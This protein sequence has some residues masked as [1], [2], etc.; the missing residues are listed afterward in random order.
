MKESS[1][2][3]NFVF[4]IVEQDEFR[5][6]SMTLKLKEREILPVC[7]SYGNLKQKVSETV[8]DIHLEGKYPIIFLGEN[9]DFF[10]EISDI[11]IV[12]ELVNNHQEGGLLIPSCLDCEKQKY[13]WSFFLPPNES[14]WVVPKE[15]NINI[16]LECQNF[17]D[18]LH[19]NEQSVELNCIN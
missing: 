15:A 5:L 13:E 8:K 3:D 2:I 1:V 11:R 18:N 14:C 6:K 10:S 4:V 12:Q 17:L 19:S 7:I 16:E 9:G